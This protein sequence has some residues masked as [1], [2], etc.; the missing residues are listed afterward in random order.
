VENRQHHD[1]L[2]LRVKVDAVRESCGHHPA[3]AIVDHGVA[4]RRLR[5]APKAM[6]DLGDELG[7][8]ARPLRLV[9]G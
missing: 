4:R 5:D 1:A 9:P 2:S 6:L 7:A 8:E 3:D